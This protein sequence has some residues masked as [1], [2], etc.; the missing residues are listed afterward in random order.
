[1]KPLLLALTLALIV[2]DDSLAAD[3]VGYPEGYRDWTHV[4]SMV[5]HPG[6]PLEQP[7]L[8]IHHVY[9]NP[10]A[11]AGLSSG[12]YEDGALFVFDQL[13]FRTE[14]GASSEGDRVLLGIMGKDRKRHPDTGGWGFEA[15]KGASR[16]DRLVTDG[17]ASCF[18]CH[19]QV[20]DRDFVFTQWRN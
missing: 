14:E 18:G 20:Q 17:G 6:H 3:P 9:A 7:F 11:L 12:Q 1:M 2:A 19:T 4:K 13:E 5:I 16:T 10:K 8:G 15:W